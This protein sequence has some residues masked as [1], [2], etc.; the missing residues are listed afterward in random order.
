M[1]EVAVKQGGLSALFQS[2]KGDKVLAISF[3]FNMVFMLGES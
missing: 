3:T 2:S 1:I